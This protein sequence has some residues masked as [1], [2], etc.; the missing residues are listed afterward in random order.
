MKIKRIVCWFVSL[1][2][3]VCI[4]FPMFSGIIAW[5]WEVDYTAEE[6]SRDF[7][8]TICATKEIEY[9]NIEVIYSIPLYDN[10]DEV[11]AQVTLFNRDGKIDYAIYNYI[12]DYVDEYAFDC[13]EALTDFSQDSHIYYAGALNYYK[14]ADENWLIDNHTGNMIAKADI[15]EAI[16]SFK[17]KIDEKLDEKLSFGSDINAYN[18]FIYWGQIIYGD[19]EG[20]ENSDWGYLEGIGPGAVNNT[21]GIVGDGL[22]FSSAESFIPEGSNIENNCGPTAL[23]NI[24]IYYNWRGMDTLLNDSRQDT[25]NRLATL[26]NH[27]ND[28]ITQAEATSALQTYMSER[29]YTA[30]ISIFF[31]NFNKYKEYIDSDKVI[32]TGLSCVDIN[33]GLWNH[34]VVTLGYEEFRQ[35]Y[36]KQVLW[37]T[38]TG[39]NYL[40][41]IRV[42][43]GWETCSRG[44]FV[45]LDYF[46]YY[47]NAAISVTE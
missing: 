11:I 6:K 46:S 31:N 14:E 5:A 9:E 4:C 1:I 45:S 30:D 17:S 32:L 8:K 43:N 42:C 13:P 19:A 20:W 21:Y 10:E 28:G 38:E 47:W 16:D 39:Y 44:K 37:W 23:A 40:R 7:L 41:Y 25:Y 33:E 34:F 12:S 15:F 24:M 27:D 35:E 26:S 3:M 18:G 29:G 36:E 2:L 22:S